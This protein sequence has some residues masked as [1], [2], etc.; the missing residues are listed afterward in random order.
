MATADG[1]QQVLTVT[2]HGTDDD[3][4][5]HWRPTGH[6][7]DADGV[8]SGQSPVAQTNGG[9]K[10]STGRD[11][12]GDRS[13]S[14]MARSR[15]RRSVA[16]IYATVI[17]RGGGERLTATDPDSSNAFVATNVNGHGRGV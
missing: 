8:R 17:Q 7:A 6:G 10:F 12:D 15:C 14:S 3:G 4:E 9:A 16:P 13:D 11:A 2:M 1:T 5:S